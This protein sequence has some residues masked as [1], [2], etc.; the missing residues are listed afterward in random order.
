MQVTVLRRLVQL[1]GLLLA[2]LLLRQYV[3]ILYGMV[4]LI[5]AG[6]ILFTSVCCY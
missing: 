3:N 5:C 4:A 2:A 1:L 6:L